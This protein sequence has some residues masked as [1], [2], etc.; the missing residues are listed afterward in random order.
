[1]PHRHPLSRRT[2]FPMRVG[3]VPLLRCPTDLGDLVHPGHRT[4]HQPAAGMLLRG[5]HVLIYIHE[6]AYGITQH[7]GGADQQPGRLRRWEVPVHVFAA[8]TERAVHAL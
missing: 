6:N 3:S 5:G 1:M 8:W 7:A 2:L 4:T